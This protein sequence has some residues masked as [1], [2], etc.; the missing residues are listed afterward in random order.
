MQ[1]HFFFV[2]RS[3][4]SKSYLILVLLITVEG[5]RVAQWCPASQQCGPSSNPGADAISGLSLLLVLSFAPKGFSPGTPV[6]PSPQKP[7]FPNSNSTRKGRR[8]TTA[9]VL[10]LNL[11]MREFLYSTGWTNDMWQKC[12]AMVSLTST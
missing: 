1:I 8:R 3:N 10:P 11:K 7:I 9:Y 12:S 5:E 6:Y 4:F 2:E